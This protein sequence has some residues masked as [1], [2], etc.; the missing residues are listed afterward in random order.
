MKRC[1]KERIMAWEINLAFGGSDRVKQPKSS[2]MMPVF[3]L[4]LKLGTSQTQTQYVTVKQTCSF[5][6]YFQ[7][8][9]TRGKKLGQAPL[10]TH[11]EFWP[12]LDGEQKH[13]FTICIMKITSTKVRPMIWINFSSQSVSAWKVLQSDSNFMYCLVQSSV[14][15]NILQTA[16]IYTV[17]TILS[18]YTVQ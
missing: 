11:T 5:K 9:R 7:V 3:W 2:V 14:T 17:Q 13:S 6:E 8:G 1:W 4:A 18:K 16:G 15:F 10:M 12:Q